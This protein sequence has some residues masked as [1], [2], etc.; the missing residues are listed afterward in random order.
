MSEEP[1]ALSLMYRSLCD[2]L[3]E[4][5]GHVLQ[6]YLGR[7]TVLVRLELYLE[8]IGAISLLS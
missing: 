4:L 7:H 2:P 8:L 1:H 6:R 3:P 5:V